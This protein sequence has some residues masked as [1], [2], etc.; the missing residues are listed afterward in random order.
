MHN[1]LRPQSDTSQ[2]QRIALSRTELATA[3]GVSQGTVD[4][5]AKHH[6]L[7]H[8]KVSRGRVIFPIDQ[9]RAWLA[10]KS[11]VPDSNNGNELR[12]A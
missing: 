9:V 5:W 7:P 10:Q 1:A 12:S 6:K 2:P 4:S 3:L 8:L 11:T